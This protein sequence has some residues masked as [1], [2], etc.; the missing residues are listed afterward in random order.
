VKEVRFDIPAPLGTVNSNAEL[1]DQIATLQAEKAAFAN[2]ARNASSAYNA[3]QA[4]LDQTTRER[5]SLAKQLKGAQADRRAAHERAE[6][7]QSRLS[8]ATSDEAIFQQAQLLLHDENL[9]PHL[10][11]GQ[12][13]PEPEV[14]PAREYTQEGKGKRKE[15][16]PEPTPAESS[17]AAH[18]VRERR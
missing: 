13:K 18:L 15:R 9:F 16:S 1:L 3:L 8:E 10:F 17:L 12:P 2:Q 7:L 4:R 6:D 5:E 14:P 11:A